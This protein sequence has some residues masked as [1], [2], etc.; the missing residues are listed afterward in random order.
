[1]GLIREL[2]D[3]LFPLPA[4]AIHTFPEPKVVA[5]ISRV[6]YALVNLVF[7][8]VDCIVMPFLVIECLNGSLFSG[9]LKGMIIICCGLASLFSWTQVIYFFLVPTEKYL[10]PFWGRVM[11]ETTI[12]VMISALFQVPIYSII[13]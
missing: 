8:C 12:G 3:E 7:Q 1:M 10:R 11:G 2:V 9:W 4:Q 5:A 13:P 6:P